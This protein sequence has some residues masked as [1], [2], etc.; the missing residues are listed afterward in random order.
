MAEELY[1]YCD[2][3]GVK[4]LETLKIKV[5]PP[6]ELNDPFEALPAFKNDLTGEVL[7][8]LF[9]N[10]EWVREQLRRMEDSP[11]PPPRDAIELIRKVGDKNQ[12][13]AWREMVALLYAQSMT[14]GVGPHVRETQSVWSQHLGFLCLSRTPNDI[15]MWAHYAD[16]H[17]GLVIGFDRNY[18]PMQERFTDVIYSPQR[19]A[20]SPLDYLSDDAEQQVDGTLFEM[21][22]ISGP[23]IV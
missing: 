11:T 4:I 5:T 14:Q 20:V 3:D 9:D 6:D 10:E 21:Q 7:I 12:P 17:R 16:K 22:R 1:K 23:I 15:P 13:Q 2:E 8:R 19:F 18:L